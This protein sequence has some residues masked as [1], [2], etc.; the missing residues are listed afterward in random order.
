MQIEHGTHVRDLLCGSAF[1]DLDAILSLQL[2]GDAQVQ[3]L[4]GSP[5]HVGRVSAADAGAWRDVGLC[6]QLHCLGRDRA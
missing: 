5:Q 6:S 4:M 1:A 2:P 3:P